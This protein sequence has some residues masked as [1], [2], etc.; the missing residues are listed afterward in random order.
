MCSNL[1][2]IIRWTGGTIPNPKYI[3]PDIPNPGIKVSHWALTN[4]KNTAFFA[5]HLIHMFR[6]IY[7][8]STDLVTSSIAYF[9]GINQAEDAYTN[10]LG[11]P[12]LNK[13]YCIK[14]QIEDID[15]QLL[16]NI[17]IAKAPLA[18]VVRADVSVP[19]HSTDPSNEYN[20][21]HQ[22]MVE[23]MPHK[24]TAYREDNIDAWN[25]VID[26]IHDKKLSLGT[27]DVNDVVTDR[28]F[29]SRWWTIN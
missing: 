24:H 12:T 27:I 8:P 18:W 17:G 25:I 11:I 3:H 15:A 9:S 22:E 7:F 13:I 28:Q 1:V 16:K 26:S 20:T 21:V 6:P 19:A 2:T 10:L 4:L 5:C 23:I 14:N 29:T